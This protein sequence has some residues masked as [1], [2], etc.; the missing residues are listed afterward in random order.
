MCHVDYSIY[1]TSFHFI[2]L[3]LASIQYTPYMKGFR[4][5]PLLLFRPYIQFNLYP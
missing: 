3:A 2:G 5:Y 1:V 4:T